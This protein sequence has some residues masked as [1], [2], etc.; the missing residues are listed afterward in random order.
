L[1]HFAAPLKR[2]L[3]NQAGRGKT[4]DN[5]T[6]FNLWLHVW[7][8]GAILLW[9]GTYGLFFADTS[10]ANAEG[11]LFA[12]VIGTFTTLAATVGVLRHS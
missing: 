7:F 11:L 5:E 6:K 12:F 8:F 4:M 1:R 2:A 3:G 10:P 9:C